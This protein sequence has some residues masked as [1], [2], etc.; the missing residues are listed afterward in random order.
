MT[1]PSLMS[2]CST[3][4]LAAR[5]A[6]AGVGIAEREPRSLDGDDEV[7]SGPGEQRRA[8]GID[9]DLDALV[10]HQDVAGLCLGDEAHHVLVSG[11]SA[12]LHHDAQTLDWLL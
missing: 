1:A 11:A 12:G 6:R 10:F 8:V 5:A 9:E 7:D 4:R 3:E 2:G